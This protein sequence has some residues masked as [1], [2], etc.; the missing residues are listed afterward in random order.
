MSISHRRLTSIFENAYR[1]IGRRRSIPVIDIEFYPYTELRHT[2]RE[3]SRHVYVRISDIFLDAPLEVHRALAF[4]MVALLFKKRASEEYNR[5]YIDY[6]R[7]PR[8]RKARSQV[9]RRRGYKIILTAQG[10]YYDLDAMFE[11]LN[12]RYFGGSLRKPVLTW[13]KQ[14]T[15]STLGNHD[16]EHKVITI[17]RRLDSA[18]VPRWFVEYILYHEMLHVKHPPRFV[19][20]R[21]RF[22]TKDFEADEQRFLHYKEAIRWYDRFIRRQATSRPRAA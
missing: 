19:N 5:I 14:N 3:R 7:L 20:G 13:S 12:R 18:S 8:I 11:R 9:R 17:S 2:I 6:T 4:I 22:H 15:I 10:R 1:Q 21:Y 16:P